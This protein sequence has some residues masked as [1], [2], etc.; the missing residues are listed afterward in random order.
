MTKV[1][2]SM[3][4]GL[5]IAAVVVCVSGQASALVFDMDANVG[6]PGVAITDVPSTSTAG[7]NTIED[8][9]IWRG[10]GSTTANVTYTP[11]QLTGF[12]NDTYDIYVSW[13]IWHTHSDNGRFTV[14]H[15]A[16]SSVFDQIR[17][18]QTSAQSTPNALPTQSSAADGSGWYYLGSF[19]LDNTSTIVADKTDTAPFAHDGI[20]L[21][22][23][24][25]GRLI[26][27]YSSQVTVTD[28]A[29][30]Q[31]D[32]QDYAA[33]GSPPQLGYNYTEY[34]DGETE[35]ATYDLLNSQNNPLTAGLYEIELSWAAH[36][37]HTQLAK[38]LVDLN[39]DGD[40]DDAGETTVTI[41]QE[42][43]A[44]Q[45]T[46][47]PNAGS[48]EWSGFHSIGQFNLTANSQIILQEGLD[49]DTSI[50]M[51]RVTLV[52]EPTSMLTLAAAAGVLGWRRRRK[53][54]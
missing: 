15:T 23:L 11:S 5:M 47:G 20:R 12:Q 16:G 19:I 29:N 22:T 27:E 49:H 35:S 17:L 53:K 2:D 28:P 46:A 37:L 10:S 3:L 9:Y 54:A 45:F 39:G 38:Y 14:N 33:P 50:D 51:L 36:L 43:L 26:D 18:N 8:D 21:M 1:N 24:D 42:L 7:T 48:A 40:A 31:I 32:P 13:G 6:D 41:N 44:D 52:P 34:D 30:W 4:A 25:E